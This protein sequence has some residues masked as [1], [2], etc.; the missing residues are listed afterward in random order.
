MKRS[1]AIALAGVVLLLAPA[2]AAQ[3]AKP[4][5]SLDELLREVQA[6]RQQEQELNRRREE[7]FRRRKAEQQAL[8]GQAEGERARLEARSAELERVFQE[9]E[10]TLAV[11]DE[12]LRGRL[13]S[14]GELF[15]VV[16]QVAGDTR[17][18]VEGSIA[19]AQHPGRAA[20]LDA[21]AQSR[22]LPAIEQLEEL[23]YRL[24]H[25]MTE[26]GKVVRFRAPVVL[27]DG[28]HEEREVV[29]VGV[30]SA[31]S[32]GEFL[33]YQA[34][35]EGASEGSLALL[36]RQPGGRFTRA[37]DDFAE[38]S[39]GRED[40]PI[41][42]S[43]GSILGLLVQAPTAR[44]RIDQ[45]GP[46]GYTI[47]VLGIVGGALAVWRFLALSAV[48]RRVAAQ[49]RQERGSPD[50][51]LGRLM[52][53]YEANPGVA[54]ETL[55]LRLDEAVMREL[56]PLERALTTIRVISVVAPL[57]GLLGTVTGMIKTFQVITLFGTGDPKMMAAGIA[58]ALVTTMLGLIVAI[59]LTFL[60]SLVSDRS[61][62]VT[63][64]LDEQA[65]G[66]IARRAEAPAA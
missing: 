18:V 3:E 25:E 66:M 22:K 65:A 21:I 2:L 9:N 8:L 62:A 50:N 31:L 11:L 26:S 19:S 55:E 45:G 20:P 63:E 15:G 5:K 52:Q 16:R 53:V 44:E 61:K 48:G 7:E 14:L 35:K 64:V 42:P 29:R 56:P 24:Q 59:P 1:H 49:A 51:P 27:P 38:A 17:S 10:R 30:F 39:D 40:A 32:D 43:K 28:S 46:V 23:W 57:L 6:G 13:G 41:D 47:I 54:T 36:P 4:G 60:H 37:A 12:Q 34:P 33:V 58:E